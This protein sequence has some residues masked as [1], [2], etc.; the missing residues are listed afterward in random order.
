MKILPI[1]GD[2]TIQPHHPERRHRRRYRRHRRNPETGEIEFIDIEGSS[3]GEEQ[4]EGEGRRR[5]GRRHRH[6][7]GEETDKEHRRYR[8]AHGFKRWSMKNGEDQ[9]IRPF[10]GF[11][12]RF[13]RD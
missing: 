8:R 13:R 12:A 10:G 6:G 5:H 9:P 3:A 11:F 4:L 2:V 7:D 1:T